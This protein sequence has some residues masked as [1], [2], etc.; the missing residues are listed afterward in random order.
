M[1][2]DDLLSAAADVARNTGAESVRIIHVL[3]A[4]R[5]R[6]TMHGGGFYPATAGEN[7]SDMVNT[8]GAGAPAS[9]PPMSPRLERFI[10]EIHNCED[11]TELARLL[12][13]KQDDREG[14]SLL[15][16]SGVL[17]VIVAND[18]GETRIEN[19]RVQPQ[20]VTILD[21]ESGAHQTLHLNSSGTYTPEP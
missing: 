7:F 12:M 8:P 14:T 16:K 15:K 19:Q 5:K 6:L 17:G 3:E 11:M 4:T 2:Q 10:P 9:T 18:L 20:Q 1:F 13:H 21:R